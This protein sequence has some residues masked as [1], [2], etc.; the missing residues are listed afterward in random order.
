LLNPF[1]NNKKIDGKEAD[2]N[3]IEVK[4]PLAKIKVYQTT[5]EVLFV[6]NALI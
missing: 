5:I 2:K 4:I 1:Y 3:T 6:F